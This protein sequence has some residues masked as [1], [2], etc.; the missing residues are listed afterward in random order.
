M[1]AKRYRTYITAVWAR[2]RTILPQSV[3]WDSVVVFLKRAR[4]SWAALACTEF[5]RAVEQNS[6]LTTSWPATRERGADILCDGFLRLRLVEEGFGSFCLFILYSKHMQ[7]LSREVWY[8]QLRWDACCQDTETDAERVCCIQENNHIEP[9][10]NIGDFIQTFEIPVS[11]GHV[12]RSKAPSIKRH[13]GR[14]LTE[15]IRR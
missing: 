4:S 1:T 6:L 12:F 11:D 5:V 9:H 2:V 7:V 14:P 10:F 15:C 8:I 13:V 3:G